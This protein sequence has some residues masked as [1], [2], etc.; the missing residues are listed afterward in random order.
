MNARS[1]LNK[2]EDFESLLLEHAPDIVGITETWLTSDIFNHEFAPPNYSVIRKDRPSRGG[3]VALLIKNTI[4]FTPLPAIADTEAVFTRIICNDFPIFI[5]CFYRSPQSGPEPIIALQS[6][7]QN[8]VQNSRLILLGDFNL[9]DFDWLSMRYTSPGSSALTDLM[10]NFNLH[11]VVRH[12]TRTQGT[13]HNILDLILLSDLFP[14]QESQTVV[15]DGF[16][17]HDIP[18]CTLPLGTAVQKIHTQREVVNFN[19]ADDASVTTYLAHEFQSFSQMASDP[20]INVNDLWLRFKSIIV[21]SIENFIPLK[22]LKTRKHNPWITRDVIHAKRKVKRLRRTL[23]TKGGSPLVNS[24]LKSATKEFKTQV[25]NAKQY[26]F[27]E[28]LPQFITNNPQRFWNYFRTPPTTAP[29][30]SSEEKTAKAN[31]FNDYF[32]SVFISD[33][34][35]LPTLSSTA[36]PPIDPLNIADAGIF[37]LLLNLDHKKANGP[38]NIP[39]EFLKR[40]AELCSHYLGIVFRKSLETA[41][42]P[43]D[44]KIAKVVPIHKSGDDTPCNYRPIS[45]ISTCCKIMEHII[46]KHLTTFL[47]NNNILTPHQHGFRRNLSTTTQLAEVVHDLA[48]T[49]NNRGQT[50]IILLDFTK[51]FD[52]VSHAKLISKLRAIIGEGPITAWITSFLSQRLQYTV[53]DQA[54]SD[55]VPVTSGVPQGSVLG[56]LLFLIFINDITCNLDCHIKLFADDCIIYKEIKGPKD[57]CTLNS[58]LQKIAEWCNT[59]QMSINKKKSVCMTITAKKNPSNFSYVL[60]GTVLTKVNQH[61][62]LGVTLTSTLQWDSHIDIIT[63]TALRKLFFL[64]R[65]LRLAPWRTKLLAYTTFVRPILEYA[66]V[67]WFPHTISSRNKI[68][69]VQRKAIRFIYNRYTRNDS[70]TNLLL[71][72]GLSTLSDRARVARLK[73]LHQVLHHRLKIDASKYISLSTSRLSRRKHSYTLKEYSF[74]ND[75]FQYSLFPLAVKEWNELDP[76]ISNTVCFST[77]CKLLD[78]D[79]T[80]HNGEL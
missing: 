80:D 73:F 7:M 39:N 71:L 38:D 21:N 74:H 42:L 50:D 54:P 76:T 78:N 60:E 65:R 67:V 43:D 6:F 44:W 2:S 13:A 25:T 68:E 1:I 24:R 48:L 53:C 29:V 45:L 22:T 30:V 3:G 27:N 11:Q 32:H 18:K 66:N 31:Q 57:H 26:Y 49:I 56:P 61:K 17:D 55:T 33:N 52:C 79:S 69:R 41:Q 63:S 35:A 62:Y 46:L 70:P 4:P 58:S 9:P 59:W 28:T 34:G 20:L 72:A 8:Y 15:I 10:L 47:E 23:K 77:F 40:Y 16:S 36:D 12:P 14:L 75:T 37:N 64:R 5:G 19:R 51:A